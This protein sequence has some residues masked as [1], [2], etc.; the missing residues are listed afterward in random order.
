MKFFTV[1]DLSASYGKH[2]IL[3]RLSFETNVSET[4]GSLGANG[5]GKTTL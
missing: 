2:E 3:S 5:S 1:N 4:I